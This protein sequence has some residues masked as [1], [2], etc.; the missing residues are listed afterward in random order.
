MILVVMRVKTAVERERRAVMKMMV[1]DTPGRKQ[2]VS[3]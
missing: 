3:E 1:T 2:Q